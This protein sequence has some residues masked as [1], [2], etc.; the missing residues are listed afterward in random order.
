MTTKRKF[1]KKNKIKIN[2]LA[3]N[4]GL[5][6]ESGIGKTSTL[7]EVAEKLVGEDGYMLLS[8]GKEDAVDAIAN[9][10]YE[11]VPDWDTFIEITDDIIENKQTDYKDLQVLIYDTIDQLF[12]IAE[13]HVI[14]LH[15]KDAKPDKRA[16]TINAAFGGY[17]KG[18]DKVIEIILDRIWELKNIGVHMIC[19]GHTKRKTLSD[20]ST[21]EEYDMLTTNMSE[22]YFNAIKTKL[23][24]LGV[25]SVDR[26]IEYQ[27]VKQRMGDDKT[28]GK[29]KSESRI[30][31]FRD[32]NFNIDSKSRFAEITPRINLNA[33][34]FIKA[35]EDAIKIEMAKDKSATGKTI[36]EVKVEQEKEYEEKVYQAVE[37]A[38]DKVDVERNVE[39]ARKILEK[40]NEATDE[41]KQNVI[42]YMTEN[43]VSLKEVE[44]TSTSVY[45]ATLA[46]FN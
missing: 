1:G 45:E 15:N 33:D 16:K 3:Y 20:V 5:I 42:A 31:T 39:L 41:V 12:T 22:K 30:I 7:I 10:V 43:K 32:D 40:S 4:I 14:A 28:V 8:L 21:G 34:E 19:V 9:A 13:P 6:G 36:E 24:F 27:K 18:G 17:G 23:H 11:E 2:P 26:S 25:A 38:N 44:N 29:V 46:Q 37:K 35:M